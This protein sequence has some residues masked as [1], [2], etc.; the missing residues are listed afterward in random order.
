[1]VS[2]ENAILAASIIALFGSI[3]SLY[4]ATTLAVRKER[5][6]LLWSREHDRFFQLEELAGELVEFLGGYRPFPKD[7]TE[8][9][10]KLEALERAAGRFGRY[11]KVRQTIRDLHN[12]LSRMSAAKHDSEDDRAIRKE[13]NPAYLKLLET[14]D[15]VLRRNRK[16]II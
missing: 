16:G 3:L 4:I 6:Q 9:L 5:R 12:V 10:H 14:C 7:S 11:P 8:L 15:K 2:S 1:M 13:L